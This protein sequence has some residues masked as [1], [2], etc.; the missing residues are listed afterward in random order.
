MERKELEVFSEASNAA[1]V[2]MPGR[3]FPGLVIQGDTFRNWLTTARVFRT[4]AQELKDDEL[5]ADSE[6][7]LA[8]LTNLLHHYEKVLSA[9]KMD[10]PYIQPALALD[11]AAA[12]R[13]AIGCGANIKATIRTKAAAESA[14][15]MQI[16]HQWDADRKAQKSDERPQCDCNNSITM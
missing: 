8:V 12:F 15:T 11:G 5:L 4:R 2:R 16:F 14:V 7:F 6:E 1:I 13:T 3:R 9:H 10:L